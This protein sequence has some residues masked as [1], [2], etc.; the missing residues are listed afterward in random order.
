MPRLSKH[1]PLRSLHTSAALCVK[2]KL[3]TQSTQ[4]TAEN[5]ISRAGCVISCSMD[6]DAYLKRINYT[7]PLA[8]TAETLRALQLAH[9]FA[10]PFENLSIHAG[11]PIV[12]EDEA[13]FRKIVE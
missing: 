2:N 8:P 10:V 13:L 7:G 9:L 3:L 12:L 1:H 5:F 4:R 11:E 6:I